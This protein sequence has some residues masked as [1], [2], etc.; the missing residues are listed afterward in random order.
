MST[1]LVAATVYGIV[2]SYEPLPT[3]TMLPP[4]CVAY[5][6][7]EKGKCTILSFIKV[8]SCMSFYISLVNTVFK[9]IFTLFLCLY[10]V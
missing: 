8:L 9:I 3:I 4:G 1:S 2:T 10:D 6:E 7:A 5:T